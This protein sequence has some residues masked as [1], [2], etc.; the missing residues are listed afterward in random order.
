MIDRPTLS[1]LASETGAQLA[2]MG[3]RPSDR[4]WIRAH[5][6]TIASLGVVARP[7]G[8]LRGWIYRFARRAART[9]R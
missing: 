1:R 8:F 9:A 3:V 6:D 5:A 4:D 2:E 7:V